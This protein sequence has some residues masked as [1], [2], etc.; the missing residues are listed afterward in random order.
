MPGAFR[1]GIVAW[2]ISFMKDY[3]KLKLCLMRAFGLAKD[4]SP[5]VLL[6]YG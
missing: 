4:K 2:L 5:R 3:H 1:S 6:H